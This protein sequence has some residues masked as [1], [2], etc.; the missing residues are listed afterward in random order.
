[1]KSG[2]PRGCGPCSDKE[3][4]A[5]LTTGV[6]TPVEIL[7]CAQDDAKKGGW[8]IWNRTLTWRIEDDAAAVC[9]GHVPVGERLA[10]DLSFDWSLRGQERLGH[11][12][13]GWST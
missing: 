10:E 13:V 1:M 2:R 4:F 8:G 7:R 12:I 6:G 11:F 3:R 5:L 9:Q